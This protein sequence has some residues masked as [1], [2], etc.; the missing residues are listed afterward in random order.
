MVHKTYQTQLDES[1]IHD[2]HLLR[3]KITV[4]PQ[5]HVWCRPI[6]LLVKREPPLNATWMPVGM[7]DWVVGQI[8]IHSINLCGDCIVMI[9]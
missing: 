4:D 5:D 6:T 1:T 9:L 8:L 7:L 2:L 3:S